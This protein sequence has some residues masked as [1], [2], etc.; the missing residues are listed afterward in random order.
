MVGPKRRDAQRTDL[1]FR[2]VADH[3]RMLTFAVTD[4]ALPGIAMLTYF[5]GPDTTGTQL[6]SAPTDAGTY[7][8]LA[9][10][11]GSLD[12]TAASGTATYTIARATP[13][14]TGTWTS[15]TPGTS[16]PAAQ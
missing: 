8:V 1:A 16:E 14:S 4:G 6:P 12:Y 3:L 15:S 5:A 2:V 13:A 10:Y 7:T 11:T 9:S